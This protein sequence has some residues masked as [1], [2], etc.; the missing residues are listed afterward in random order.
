MNSIKN[1]YTQIFLQDNFFKKNLLKLKKISSFQN[2]YFH[3]DLNKKKVVLGIMAL[4]I[5]T[6]RKGIFKVTHQEINNRSGLFKQ[7]EVVSCILVLRKNQIYEILQRFLFEILPNSP[8]YEGIKLKGNSLG[9]KIT[10]I[11]NVPV[12]IE[13]HLNLLQDFDIRVNLGNV[14]DSLESIEFFQNYRLYVK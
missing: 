5:L 7:G 10:K 13:I 3:I 14:K 11:F 1:H 12:P 4:E 8:K 6:F 9:M 2:I